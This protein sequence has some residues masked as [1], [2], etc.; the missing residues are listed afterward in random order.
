MPQKISVWEYPEDPALAPCSKHLCVVFNEIII[1][2]TRRAIC[3]TEKGLPPMYYIPPQDVKTEHLRK[4]EQ[5][6]QCDLMG[7]AHY[8]TVHVAECEA[9]SAVWAYVDEPKGPLDIQGYF[10]FYPNEMDACYV[11]DEVVTP[12]PVAFYG[13]WV[14]PEIEGPFVG[15]PGVEHDPANACANK[16]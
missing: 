9:K 7:E 1:A 12:R 16:S 3:C 11:D 6:T 13:G 15:D 14:T 5:T 2:E 10:C 4:D 8:W